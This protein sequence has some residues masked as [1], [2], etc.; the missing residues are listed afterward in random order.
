MEVGRTL[1]RWGRRRLLIRRGCYVVR[2]VLGGS[3]GGI[4]MGRIA[5]ACSFEV[6]ME[7]T[8]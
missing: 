4:W 7:D 3:A 5:G 2:V 1:T 6:Q 8:S